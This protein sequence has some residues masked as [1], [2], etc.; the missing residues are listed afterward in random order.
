MG[1]NRAQFARAM[2]VHYTTVNDWEKGK[3]T[4]NPENLQLAADIGRTTVEWLMTGE[5]PT[6]VSGVRRKT[7]AAF[8][9]FLKNSPSIK[10]ASPDHLEILGARVYPDGHE[11]TTQTYEM[12]LLELKTL[13]KTEEDKEA[14]G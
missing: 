14:A 11:P 9:E 7:Y 6:P 13:E 1:M 5:G 8:A 4:P 3:K 2:D 12:A 10:N